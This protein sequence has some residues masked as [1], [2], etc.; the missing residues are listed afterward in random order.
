MDINQY[1]VNHEESFSFDNFPSSENKKSL[2][3]DIKENIIPELAQQ[4]RSLHLKLHAAEENG[5]LVVLQALDAAGKDEV[6]SYIFSNLSAQG[7][8]TTSFGKPTDTERKHDYLWRFHDGLPER[9][10]IGILNR[11]YYED[12]LAPRIHNLVEEK[13]KPDD[14]KEKNLW[15]TRY[16]QINDY[17]RYL[18]ENG[19]HVIKFFFNMSHEEQRNRL[20]ERMTNPD[21]NWEFSFNDV[22][23]REYWEDY[24]KLFSEMLEETSTEYSSWYVLPAD[25]EWHTRRIV[26][27]VMIEKIKSLN[28]QF[29]TISQEDKEDLD[30]AIE[31]LKNEQ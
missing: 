4:L 21:K 12:V 14:A 29:P 1:K 9:G 22:K 13:E 18:T 7:L 19:F 25:D 2:N 30:K 8:K 26:T 24:Q 16:R 23:E 28:P 6:I 3:D 31:R 5:I 20:L 17:E 27:E 11:S 15:H 10:Q